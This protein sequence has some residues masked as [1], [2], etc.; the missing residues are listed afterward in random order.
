MK[1][2]LFLFVFI[3]SCFTANAQLATKANHIAI[4]ANNLQKSTHFYTKIIGLT[5]VAN[6]FADTV[7]QWFSMGNNVLLHM[8]EG[9][10]KANT[11][12]RFHI[13][14][15]TKNFEKTMQYLCKEKIA[16]ENWAGEKNT[17]TRRIDGVQQIYLQD[18]DG[19]WIEIND[20]H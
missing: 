12:K 9:D 17:F 18:P 10:C 7:H 11:D 13:C 4:C 8:I 5:V 1:I 19:N 16:F 15:S 3:Y 20:E 2:Y 14:F 6:P